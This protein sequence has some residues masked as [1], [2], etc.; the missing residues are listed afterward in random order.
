MAVNRVEKYIEFQ[1]KAPNKKTRRWWVVNYRTQVIVGEVKWHGAWR[2][3]CFFP[4]PNTLYD[5]DCLEMI[6]KFMENSTENQ[7]L[8]AKWRKKINS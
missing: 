4:E 7:L 8:A 1:E 6:G 3:Y 2:K 5:W